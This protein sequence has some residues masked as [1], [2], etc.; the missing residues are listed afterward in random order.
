M[1]TPEDGATMYDR[2]WT[3]VEVMRY[4]EPGG[5]PHAREESATLMRQLLSKFSERGFGQWG[6][7]P[8]STGE[9]IGYCGLRYLSKTDDVEL[10]YG[11]AADCW[12]RGFV[13]EAARAS[14]RFGF[15]VAGLERIVAVA[16]PENTASRRV[17][18]KLGMRLE[19]HVRHLQFDVVR[20][21]IARDEFAYGEGLYLLRP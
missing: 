9:L 1:F 4:V 15:E 18:E 19:G 16:L 10:L 7:V 20:Y 13:T 14:L 17:M 2:V 11:I 12:G 6:V 3:D 8:K 5:W 21:S